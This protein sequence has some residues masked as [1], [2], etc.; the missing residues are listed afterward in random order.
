M[1]IMDGF[2]FGV[3]FALGQAC[4]LILIKELTVACD[5]GVEILKEME[6]KENE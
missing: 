1:S 3:G 2:K 4:L 5:R 6:S